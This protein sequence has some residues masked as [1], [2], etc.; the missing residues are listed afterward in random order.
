M[1]Q[2]IEISR[3]SNKFFVL[4]FFDIAGPEYIETLTNN[5]ELRGKVATEKV[6]SEV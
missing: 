4:K 2:F 3:L 5:K 6:T 1:P